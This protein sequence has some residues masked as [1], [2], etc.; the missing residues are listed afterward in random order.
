MIFLKFL[1]TFTLSHPPFFPNPICDKFN[2]GTEFPWF[3]FCLLLQLT[4]KSSWGKAGVLAGPRGPW[5]NFSYLFSESTVCNFSVLRMMFSQSATRATRTKNDLSV[6]LF[7]YIRM[8][9]FRTGWTFLFFYQLK[10]ENVLKL[11]LIINYT[12]WHFRF[13]MYWGFNYQC[14]CT[15]RIQNLF[16]ILSLAFI[17]K[18]F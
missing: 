7:L 17:L 1:S 13:R 16:Q 11:F 2:S 18:I 3:L 8:L 12:L 5:S 4:R 9:F 15:Y 10:D 6:T 14:S